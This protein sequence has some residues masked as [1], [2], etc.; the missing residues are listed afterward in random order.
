MTGFWDW[1]RFAMQLVFLVILILV[2]RGMKALLD[3]AHSDREAREMAI[4]DLRK[5]ADDLAVRTNAIAKAKAERMDD[6]F[7]SIDKELDRNT[8]L[9]VKAAEA[10]SEAAHVAN[11]MNK[12]IEAT[13]ERIERAIKSDEKL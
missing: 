10:S 2:I 4:E 6:R 5:T 12:K 3:Q 8:E 1:E 9:T 7:D 11:S 13:N